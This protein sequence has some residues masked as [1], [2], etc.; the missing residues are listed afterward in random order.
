MKQLILFILLMMMMPQS[1][2]AE[3]D[4]VARFYFDDVEKLMVDHYEADFRQRAA[5]SR[6]LPLKRNLLSNEGHCWS[7]GVGMI[8]T[9]Y[10]EDEHII[11]VFREYANDVSH[12]TEVI[13]TLRVRAGKVTPLHDSTVKVTVEQVGNY[14][15]LVYRNAQGVPVKS[16]Y[17]ISNDEMN[18]GY[19]SIF[20]HYVLDGN[21]LTGKEGEHAV[22][23]PKM[24]FYEGDRYDCDPGMYAFRD[25]DT[26]LTIIYGGGRVNHGDPSSPKYGKMPGGGGAG[27]LM[28]PMEWQVAPTVEGL[29]VKVSRDEKFVD[30]NPRVADGA[31][32]TKVK[33]PYE[34]LDGKWAFA[35]VIPLTA[36]MLKF[37]P[38]E[39]LTLMRGEIYARYGDTFADPATQRYFDDQPWY[40]RGSHKVQLTD[41]ER[42]NYALIKQVEMQKNVGGKVWKKYNQK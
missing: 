36:G 25:E 1:M 30:H 37:F 41:L 21:Y 4:H 18:N 20:M 7:D 38:R 32:L 16:F 31:V 39:V 29:K 10:L 17:S 23:G 22:F 19:W 2:S 34:R 35:S 26:C 27:A 28:G 5:G 24:S 33:C 15:M 9:L 11:V 14:K 6:V 42:F 12:P 8:V 13:D 40:K 3:T